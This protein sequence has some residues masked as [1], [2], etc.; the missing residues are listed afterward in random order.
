MEKGPH[1]KLDKLWGYGRGVGSAWHA[2][3]TERP[4]ATTEDSVNINIVN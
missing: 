4:K 3:Q 1:T 2:L